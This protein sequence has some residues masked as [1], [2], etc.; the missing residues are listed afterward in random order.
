MGGLLQ[1]SSA[2]RSARRA[3]ALRAASGQ[4]SLCRGVTE[5]LRPYTQM[6]IRAHR[7]QIIPV[8]WVTLLAF[9]GDANA[10]EGVVQSG[11]AAALCGSPVGG[12]ENGRAVPGVR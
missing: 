10:V 3:D 1:L 9:A 5:V 11:R 4:K 7:L 2:S 6:S 12:R 8:T